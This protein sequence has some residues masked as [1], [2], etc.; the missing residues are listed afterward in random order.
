MEM[1]EYRTIDKS[2]WRRGPWDNEPDK[3]QWEDESTGLP[4][5]IVRNGIGALCGYVGISEGHPWFGVAWDDIPA[6]IHGG[7]T[8]SEHCHDSSNEEQ[9]ICHVPSSGEPDHVWWLGFDCAHS[10]DLVP[11][12]GLRGLVSG[13]YRDIEYVKNEVSRLALQA[14]N[15]ASM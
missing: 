3:I 1:R 9:G 8:Y 14:R 5:L 4:C 10:G 6:D 7:L 12:M 11:H 15:A 2:E 13:T